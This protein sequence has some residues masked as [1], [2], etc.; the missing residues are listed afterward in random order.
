MS[1]PRNVHGRFVLA[2][3]SCAAPWLDILAMEEKISLKWCVHAE[4]DKLLKNTS[5]SEQQEATEDPNSFKLLLSNIALA[6]HWRV[7][8]ISIYILKEWI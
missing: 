5:R 7:L 3:Q 1:Q 2:L 6:M 8:G 4:Q